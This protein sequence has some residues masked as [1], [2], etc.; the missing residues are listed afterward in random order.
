MPDPAN[1]VV[2]LDGARTPFGKL[3]G[4]LASLSA[5]ELGSHA[6]RA[7]LDRAGVPAERV[8]AVLMGQ[9]VQAGAGQNP[10]RQSSIGAGLG[11]DVPAVTINKVCLSS[12]TAIIDGARL[13]RS[14]EAV[15]VVA[16]GQESMS[17]GPYLLPGARRGWLYDNGAVM[18]AVA[19]DG[20]S[21]AFDHRSMGAST[22]RPDAASGID[23]AAQDAA[24]ARSHQRA[25]AA[26]DAGTLTEEIAPVTVTQRRGPDRVVEADE[27]VRLDTTAQRLAALPPA[28][29]EDG[30]LT[31]GNSS[32]LS[33]GAA[34]VVLTTR[35]EAERNGWSWLSVVGRCG[36]VAGPDNSL[37][38]QPAHAIRQA[39]ARSSMEVGELDV[40][41]INE[42]FAVVLLASARELGIDP[43]AVNR[44]GG[45]V[46]LG[47]PLGASGA[48]LALHAAK[49]LARRGGG[50]AGVGLCGGGGQGEALL[51]HR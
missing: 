26:T 11:W 8:D 31:A 14:G 33:D 21:D 34:A 24:A 29:R 19:H 43:E 4:A 6:I 1:D 44:Q 2:I 37:H 15:V 12:L 16:G 38:L 3:N 18:D 25:A 9:A 47:H 36:Q 30:T 28:F 50:H 13:I 17:N 20:L 22:D 51:L 40:V 7:A 23:R 39:L 32:P 49:E 45:A 10:G 41:E 27:G 5:V 35:S 48:R 42:A 46:A